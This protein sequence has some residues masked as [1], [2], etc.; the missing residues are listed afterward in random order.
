MQLV[1]FARI[2]AET[3]PWGRWVA[4]MRWI[5]RERPMA[6]IRISSARAA[7]ASS[8]SIRNSSMMRTRWGS[9]GPCRIKRLV[10]RE[11]GG[12]ERRPGVPPGGGLRPPGR[13]GCAPLRDV[14]RS[15]RSPT[16]WARPAS[17]RRPEPPLKSM[18]SRL[19]RSGGWA[20]ASAAARVRR[21]SDLP[22]PVVPATRKW[23]PSAWRS[24]RRGPE[25]PTPTTTGSPRRVR[26]RGSSA[27]KCP[28]PKTGEARRANRRRGCPSGEPTTGPW[29]PAGGS[30][31]R[32][33]RPEQDRE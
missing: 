7:G 15:V 33:R 29:P 5:P 30:C 14:S 26:G 11:V 13:P 24:S 18:N 21:N 3:A 22:E 1:T 4:M 17:G 20:A 6:A 8:T 12:L 27:G 16:Q 31:G 28:A 19:T 10:G 23:G 25:R 9:G 32:R 2:S